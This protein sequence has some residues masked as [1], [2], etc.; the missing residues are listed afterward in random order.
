MPS[1]LV[2]VLF[3]LRCGS[4]GFAGDFFSLLRPFHLIARYS[5]RVDDYYKQLYTAY[6]SLLK[7]QRLAQGELQY[8][9]M[10]EAFEAIELD[11]DE[12]AAAAAE[13]YDG[14]VASQ[15]AEQ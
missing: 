1:L 14:L 4:D 10:G 3:S 6:P 9:I 12:I 15:N 5:A 7:P 2:L 13:R 11:R 8:Y